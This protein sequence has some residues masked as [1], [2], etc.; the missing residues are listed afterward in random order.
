MGGHGGGRGG[1]GRG[2]GL[3]RGGRALDPSAGPPEAVDRVL[4][5][6]R[7]EELHALG[8]SWVCAGH[9]LLAKERAAEG[10]PHIFRDAVL[11]CPALILASRAGAGKQVAL[12]ATEQKMEEPADSGIWSERSDT[13]GTQMA[14]KLDLASSSAQPHH[15]AG[16]EARLSFPLTQLLLSGTLDCRVRRNAL[17]QALVHRQ[18]PHFL[19]SVARRG[20]QE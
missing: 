3:G 12:A 8:D 14:T 1:E 2:E 13:S 11:P 7:G 19:R 10:T 16:G 15:K 20:L 18:R 9:N 6:D 4:E 17:G 5:A